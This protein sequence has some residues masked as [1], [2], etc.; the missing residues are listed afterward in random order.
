[1]IVLFLIL[2]CFVIFSLIV[3]TIYYIIILIGG[4]YMDRKEEYDILV[5]F[6]YDGEDNATAVYSGEI[7]RG[8]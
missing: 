5:K 3:Y 7:R 6:Q 1:M 2:I 4:I 8:R